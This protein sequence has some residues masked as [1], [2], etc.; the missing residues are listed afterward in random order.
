MEL[1]MR[2]SRE[3]LP[4]SPLVALTTMVPVATPLSGSTASAP[5]S[6]ANVP[7][8]SWRFPARWKA[9]TV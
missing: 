3:V 5:F 8:T 7:W 6:R 1:V 9:T 4:L 2:A